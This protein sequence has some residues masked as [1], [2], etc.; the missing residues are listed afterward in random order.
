MMQQRRNIQHAT[1]NN[2]MMA[3]DLDVTSAAAVVGMGGHLEPG[4]SPVLTYQSGADG[5]QH[6]S[7]MKSPNSL[8]LESK[9]Q[10]SNNQSRGSNNG[11]GSVARTHLDLVALTRINQFTA[12]AEQDLSAAE[13][14]LEMLIKTHQKGVYNAMYLSNFRA[15]L[16]DMDVLPTV[17]MLQYDIDEEERRV[18]NVV[19]HDNTTEHIQTRRA[20][21]TLH[22]DIIPADIQL[23]I[24]QLPNGHPERL[25]I[26]TLHDALLVAKRDVQ[27]VLET[28][29]AVGE[30]NQTP[31]DVDGVVEKIRKATTER[32]EKNAALE[33]AAQNGVGSNGS[34]GQ[35]ANNVQHKQQQQQQQ[36]G[37]RFEEDRH[38]DMSRPHHQQSSQQQQQQSQQSSHSSASSLQQQTNQPQ[39]ENQS[40]SSIRN[41]N[42]GMMYQR[43]GSA[44]EHDDD[45]DANVV[46]MTS[47]GGYN[48]HR[49]AAYDARSIASSEWSVEGHPPSIKGGKYSSTQS[50]SS[51]NGPSQRGN[52]G[53]GNGNGN[54]NSGSISKSN[55]AS[56]ASSSSST[57]IRASNTNRTNT[58]TMTSSIDDGD[59]R[60][61]DGSVE[62]RSVQGGSS[63]GDERSSLGGNSGTSE[64]RSGGHRN[65]DGNVDPED[66]I[67]DLILLRPD[68]V[69]G[70]ET[71]PMFSDADGNGSAMSEMGSEMGGELMDGNTMHENSLVP[72]TGVG[73]HDDEGE[74]ERLKRPSAV[75]QSQLEKE[76]GGKRPSLLELEKEFGGFISRRN[77]LDVQLA[78]EFGG[79]EEDDDVEQINNNN[80]SLSLV[81]NSDNGG[82]DDL[83]PQLMDG[84]DNAHAKKS[85]TGGGG[86]SL[87]D[88]DEKEEKIFTTKTDAVENRRSTVPP[89][90][91]TN[92]EMTIEERIAAALAGGD[93]SAGESSG[94]ETHSLTAGSATDDWDDD[95]LA[96][97]MDD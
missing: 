68:A 90:P 6:L 52:N 76:F 3:G 56:S 37:V 8:S 48:H 88:E 72:P 89:E 71:P 29:M 95:D 13:T 93:T 22:I 42:Y 83:L 61:M 26:V 2:T 78:K 81:V 77:T 17:S 20:K 36:G 70:G 43:E 92:A 69:G 96:G 12:D 41:N 18:R 16:E 58:K 73:Y 86:M 14:A 11:G 7:M 35:N 64:T 21:R 40:S 9:M 1:A 25:N 23:A 38:Y 55:Y 75:F 30:G 54:G 10:A 66:D 44:N 94:M 45:H 63:V 79:E 46:N 32:K 28:M 91:K 80:D 50:T 34:N 60:S 4:K 53:N 85:S 39:N 33:A 62:D 19:G 27:D 24:Q 84:N 87:E 65:E 31:E 97:L 67:H 49:H 15:R 74:A 51:R 47:T 82:E 5:F 57:S 59:Q